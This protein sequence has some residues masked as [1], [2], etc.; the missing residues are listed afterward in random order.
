MQTNLFPCS[1]HIS[2]HF[3]WHPCKHKRKHTHTSASPHRNSHL[4]FQ[5]FKSSSTDSVI[6]STYR[7]PDF[8]NPYWGD[9][10]NYGHPAWRSAQQWGDTSNLHPRPWPGWILGALTKS[11]AEKVGRLRTLVEPQPQQQGRA[12]CH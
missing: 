1:G 2:V 7:G 10:T 8:W 4:K 9:S 6:Q 12:K 3:P 5:K 11:D